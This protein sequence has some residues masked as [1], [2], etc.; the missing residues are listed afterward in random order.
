MSDLKDFVSKFSLFAL[1]VFGLS[2]ALRLLIPASWLTPVYSL[3]VPF[4]YL[5]GLF[6]RMLI[7]RATRNNHAAFTSAFV[8]ANMIRFMLY[9]FILIGWALRFPQQAVPFA[10]GFLVF[11]FLFTGFEVIML[12]RYLHHDE[13]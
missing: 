10:I 2:Q 6:S 13:R 5:C 9:L 1:L 3:Y 7:L 4:F 8:S 12:Y 11:Y